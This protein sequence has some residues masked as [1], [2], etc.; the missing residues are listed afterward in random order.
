M[1]SYTEHINNLTRQYNEAIRALE[2]S[3]HMEL[4]SNIH[5]L[6]SSHLKRQYSKRYDALMHEYLDKRRQTTNAYKLKHPEW[7][8]ARKLWGWI[9]F[10]G[11]MMAMVCCGASLPEEETPATSALAQQQTDHR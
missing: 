11:I 9:F 2:D 10:A 1:G 4:S 6:T 5:Q 7:A 8:K 3:Y